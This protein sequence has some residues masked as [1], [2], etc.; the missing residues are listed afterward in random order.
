ML[1]VV[2]GFPFQGHAKRVS[3][4]IS[5][6]F[7]DF[8]NRRLHEGCQSGALDGNPLASDLEEIDEILP[9]KLEIHG[10]LNSSKEVCEIHFGLQYH[11]FR[12][13]CDRYDDFF[14]IREN[15][16]YDLVVASAGGGKVG[17][18]LLKSVVR[19]RQ[20]LGPGSGVHLHVFTGPYMDGDDVERIEALAGGGTVVRRFTP[21]FPSYLAAADLSVSM[22]GYNTCMNILAAGVPA[23]V[24][25]FGLNR[26]QRM[27]AER[28]AQSAP[29]TVLDDR[30]LEPRRLAAGMARALK[31]PRRPNRSIDLNGA[32]FTAEWVTQHLG[33][34]K[35]R[36]A[37]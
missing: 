14:R 6:L 23:L 25:P 15:I 10:I 32:R 5:D 17:A 36:G 13:A 33:S 31:A 22:G 2:E 1:L 30:D 18:P 28:L 24:W 7:L 27:R 26:E 3:D 37:R 9:N 11:H 29:M 35:G 4:G 12:D 20:Q 19:A 8:E 21:D 16:A 34:R